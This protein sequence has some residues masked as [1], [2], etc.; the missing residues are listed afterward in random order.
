MTDSIP[1]SVLN[2]YN[3]LQTNGFEA[4]F[5]GG[6]VRNIIL[7]RKVKDWDFTTNATP[8]EML[9]IF[10]DGFYD[11]KFGT[12]GVPI[13]NEKQVIEITTFRTEKEYGD[14]RHPKNVTW[15]KTIEEDLQRRDFTI[16]AIAL[17][18]SSGD[19][20]EPSAFEIIDPYE[21]QKD[22]ERK[23]VKAVGDANIRFKEDAL[24]LIRAV[25][26]ATE[27]SFVIEENTWNKIKEDATLIKNVSNERVHDELLR[28]LKSDNPYE[29]IMLLNDSGLLHQIIPELT[30][31]INISQ[32][33]PGRHHTTDVFTHNALSLKF[34]PSKDP[35]VR[36]AAL[37]HDIGKPQV[38]SEDEE[39]LVIFHN[40]ETVGAKIA[41][42]ICQRLKFSK[43]DTQ[44]IVNLIRWHMFS[45]NENITDSAVRRFIRKIGVDNIKDMMDLRV[46][47][48]LGGGT[49]TAESWRLKLFKDKIEEQLKPA[50][51]SINDMAV[52]GNDVM[53]E[54]RLKPGPVIGKILEQLF[55]EVDEDLSKNNKDF[56]IKRAGE[57]VK[58]H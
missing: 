29:G 42:I 24:R 16:N 55:N 50:P 15:G 28:I 9:K 14:N 8:E 35:I 54:L 3:K 49:Q 57:L 32:V 4:Y 23:I 26:I 58:E 46:G 45:V 31:G 38:K 17:R 20:K 21:G 48:R 22:L 2:I 19:K 52:D 7:K 56:L 18:F 27:L 34:C 33:R 5:V 44:K 40:H 47:D 43:K 53:K 30:E 13:E 10:P 41:E 51:F 1:Q 25:R 12:V 39:G 11:N 37:I 36:F 6:C